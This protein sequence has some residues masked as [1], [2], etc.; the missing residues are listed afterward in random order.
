MSY[1]FGNRTA[2]GIARC[3]INQS[4]SESWYSVFND[5]KTPF[6]ENP[7]KFLAMS[8]AIPYLALKMLTFL[9]IECVIKFSRH[10]FPWVKWHL[11]EQ[12]HSS[13]VLPQTPKP[14]VSS[15]KKF[16]HS[17][18]YNI[19][20]SSI[21]FTIFISSTLVQVA[22]PVKQAVRVEIWVKML[23]LAAV[24]CFHFICPQNKN[25]P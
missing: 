6:V 2:L 7:V 15:Y 8:F 13:L 10:G 16:S 23:A 24:Y 18:Q 14:S 19:V 9:A 12:R 4:R 25:N 3:S 17:P 20:L 5:T 21:A 22:I 11:S 1:T